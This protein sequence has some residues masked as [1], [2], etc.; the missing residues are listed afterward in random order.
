MNN[1]RHLAGLCFA[2]ALSSATFAAEGQG[3]S[4]TV[5]A[6]TVQAAT[7][8]PTVEAEQKRE[9]TV[10]VSPRTGMRYVVNNPSNRKIIFQT[11]GL[12]PVNSQNIQRIVASNPAV[13]AQSQ[14][15]AQQAL[16]ELVGANQPQQVAAG[17]S[18]AETST[19]A[20]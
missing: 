11:E 15:Q 3:Q 4:I 7:A 19:V 2:M 14:Q 9:N 1:F 12:A 13:S 20:P 5:S 8:A 10:L 6:A 16:L 18:T 17:H